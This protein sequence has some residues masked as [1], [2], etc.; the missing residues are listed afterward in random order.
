[1][2]VRRRHIFLWYRKLIAEVEIFYF[3]VMLAVIFP[4][5]S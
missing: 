5:K 4:A 1:M 2:T 3:R